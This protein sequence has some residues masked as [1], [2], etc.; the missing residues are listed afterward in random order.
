MIVIFVSQCEKNALKKTRRVLDAFADRIGDNTWQTVITDEG[1]KAVQS[2][3]K[4][5]ASRSTAVS[6]HWIRSRSRSDLLWLVG[7]KDKFDHRGIVPVNYTNK[8]VF[9]DIVIETKNILANSKKQPLSQ[10]LFAV[11]FLGYKLIEKMQ[12]DNSKLAQAVFIAG[13]LHDI[14]KIDPQFQM[15]LNTKIKKEHDTSDEKLFTELPDDGVHIDTTVKGHSKFTFEK[16]PR[17]N[18]I[19]WL[20]SHSL[21]DDDSLNSAQFEQIFHSVYWHHTRPFRKENK[22]FQS[23]KGI[24]KLFEQSLDN[25]KIDRVIEQVIAVLKDV[26]VIAAQFDKHTNQ[27]TQELLPEW[28]YTIKPTKED[29]PNYKNYD[30]LADTI[31]EYT[32]EIKPNALHS[33][34]RTAL[35][36]ADRIVSAMPADDLNA[37]IV[38]GDLEQVLDKVIIDDSNLIDEINICI[39]GFSTKY[40]ESERNIKQT[41]AS[42]SLAQL[43]NRAERSN[44]RGNGKF[45]SNIG[46]LQGPAGCGKTKIALEW[47]SKT[48]AQKIIWI[49]PRVQ[50]CLGLL[51]D[52]TQKDYL[53]NSRIEIFTGEYKK[54][55][56]DGIC[57]EDAEETL[58]ADYFRGDI[59]I[60]TIDQMIKG[61]ISHSN[62]D[63][64]LDFMQAHIVFDEFHEF[65]PMPAFN[66]LFSELLEAKKFRGHR[67]NTLLISA[68][69]HDYFV[70]EVLNIDESNI[71]RVDSFNQADYQIE[72]TEYDDTDK[73]SPEPNPLVH[74]A[75]KDNKTTF[76]ITNT[77]QDAQL[78]FLKHQKSENNILL[79]SKYTRDD[80]QQWFNMVFDAFKRDGNK[81]YQILRSGPIVQASLNITCERMYTDITSAENWL[82]RLG[83]LDRFDETNEVNIYTTVM[84]K[85]IQNSKQI[86]KQ[87]KFLASLHVWQSTVA[88]LKHLQRHIEN[89][90]KNKFK[91]N[92][93]Y[94]VYQDFYQDK[95][96]QSKIEED[97]TNTLKK[98]IEVINNKVI[99][100][101]SVPPKSRKSNKGVAKIAK[102]SLRGNNRFVQMAICE[103]DEKFKPTFIN[104]YAYD[105]YTDHSTT[106]IGLTESTDKIQGG[107]FEM[108]DSEKNLLSFMKAKH[109]NIK[110]SDGVKKA[111]NDG[112]LLSEARSP[113]N[114]IYLSYTPEDLEPV[115]GERERHKFGM[116]YVKTTKQP[117]G[118]MVLDTLLNSQNCKSKNQV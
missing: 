117:I 96:C 3:L 56:F 73:E 2:L 84:P 69:P 79:H 65:I 44:K 14:G 5:T 97:I 55:L 50:V 86:S 25:K 85:T 78:A 57:L 11:G 91:I 23:G 68:T 58:E 112:V 51:N 87:A 46:V 48:N 16:Y 104:E 29:T 62:I 72:F 80:K 83:R 102:N 92:E 20:F 36:S 82:Q 37:Y 113:E 110:K 89:K 6:C 34:A 35:I 105:E 52:L 54:T 40:P 33:L 93:L 42:E 4:K 38:E 15:W 1:L 61:V 60:T 7:K 47:A 88:W 106:T 53:P 75:I 111:Y 27:K 107:G 28:N 13:V 41:E 10:H 77:A 19:S 114:P 81:D 67:A 98:S 70:K 94:Q 103:V 26:N 32:A 90:Q 63:T 49:C 59:V 43:I 30:E 101:I 24:Y 18:E 22:F 100:P 71:I 99:D 74:D 45:K 116:Y 66:L 109:H 118:T 108:R 21:L 39:Q 95:A 12:I 76:V 115:G 17:H 64:M 8:E 31:T 9:M